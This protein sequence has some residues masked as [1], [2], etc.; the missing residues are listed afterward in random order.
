MVI[1]EL[2]LYVLGAVIFIKL[3]FTYYDMWIC[4]DYKTIVWN[5]YPFGLNLFYGFDCLTC[6]WDSGN[7]KCVEIAMLDELDI[8]ILF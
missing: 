5:N 6:V 7:P 8:P 4:D 2:Y 3:D 1:V